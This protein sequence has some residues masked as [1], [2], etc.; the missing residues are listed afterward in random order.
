MFKLALIPTLVV[1]LVTPLA[2]Q[3]SDSAAV[4][5]LVRDPGAT[6]PFDPRARMRTLPNG[7]RY[8]IRPNARPA[9]RVELRLV[10]NAGSVVE[11][12]DQRGLAHV[13]EHMAFNGT[14]RFAKQ[15][16]IDFI[17]R[18]GM[19][20]GADLNA[21]TGFD[22]TI[23]QLQLPSDTG[24]YLAR[25]LDWFAD[26]A[27][28]GIT[29]DSLELEKERPVVI[30]EWRLGRGADE[31]IQ[32][33]QFPV[34]FRNSR[35]AARLPIGTKESLDRF[36]RA[37]VARFYRDW[38]RPDLMA[39]VV[40]GDIDPDSVE[41]MIVA[42]FG[43]IAPAPASARARELGPVPG[44]T[45]TLVG[46]ASDP[47]A[48]ASTVGVLWKQTI[49]PRTSVSDYR[50]ELGAALF[51]AMLNDR[52]QEITRKPSAPF[53]A[54]G[55]SQ[56]R[57]VRALEMFSLTAIVDDGGIERG[58]GALLTEAERARRL[59][60]TATELDRAKAN[61]QRS[62]EIQLAERDKT[63]SNAFAA[64]YAD[65]FLTGEQIMG[66]EMRAPL[67]KAL[68]PTVTLTEVNA[69]AQ[70]MLTEANRVILASAP[71]R[72]N[73]RMPTDSALRAIASGVR[74]AQMT[75]YRDDVRSGTLVPVPPTPGRVVSEREIPALG[76]TAWVLSNGVRVLV[77]QTD[78]SADRIIISGVSLG[79]AAGLTPQQYYSARLAPL[80]LERGGAG[81]V[82][83]DA[84]G[85]MLTGKRAAVSADI[86]DREE[87][88]SGE[89]SLRDLE[90]FFEVLWAKVTT[91]R[92]DTT[93]LLAFRQ[94]Y[95]AMV[96]DRA[97]NPLATFYDTIGETMSQKHPLAKPVSDSIVRTLSGQI[98]LEIYRDRFRDFSDFTFVIVGAASAAAVRPLV[99]RG[100]DRR[101]G[102]SRRS[103]GKAL[104]RKPRPT[105]SSAVKRR[106]RAMPRCARRP[107][108][109]SWRSGC[110]KP[111][112]RTSAARTA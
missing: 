53:I 18:A 68:L 96:R 39:V 80:M 62:M 23:Y 59:G 46:A 91:P 90:T 30:E 12:D 48:S 40:V 24:N 107:L 56:G 27:G 11:D 57:L 108:P 13:L 9:K 10:V 103:S 74:A 6:L 63:E 95:I 2:A 28:G 41:S 99:E 87:S 78:F 86:G 25:G 106:G 31:R 33:K 50:R 34:L 16:I 70:A 84:L 36:T 101:P 3:T 15:Q 64:R 105:S 81:N 49:A 93:A 26:I 14:R 55:A 66:I 75:E 100:S 94:Q 51:L 85:K 47:E 5:A 58:L 22:E 102:E 89:T 76:V 8:Y 45:E 79:G 60:F 109:V 19:K 17:E 83:A 104:T 43:S 38:Y 21:G 112:A 42:R 69:L 32:E 92:L 82:D 1:S 20:F 37:A 72:P 61:V 77:K 7:L 65:H 44:H 110:A 4:A 111:C 98:A 71:A 67:V 52:Y 88:I 54:A 73:R 29:L 97:N 35:Y